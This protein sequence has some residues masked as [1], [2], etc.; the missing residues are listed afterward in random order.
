MNT[1][2]T[3][4]KD[5]SCKSAF[6]LIEMLVVIAIIGFLSSMVSVA[7]QKGLD[8]GKSMGCRSNIKQMLVA[9][10]AYNVDHRGAF[11]SM[12]SNSYW[13]TWQI[14]LEEYLGFEATPEMSTPRFLRCP[15][16]T[17]NSDAFYDSILKGDYG[18]NRRIVNIFETYTDLKIHDI[19]YPTT[20]ILFADELGNWQRDIFNSDFDDPTESRRWRHNGSINFGFMDGHIEGMKFKDIETRGYLNIDNWRYGWRDGINN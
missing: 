14:Q 10:M 5:R 19:N 16:Q 4:T 7:V 18:I 3:H 12:K 17:Y 1:H 15:A 20:T 11:P 8:S 9:V 6:T 13:D 2:H